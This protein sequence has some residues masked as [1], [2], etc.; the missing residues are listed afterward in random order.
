MTTRVVMIA[1]LH[2]GSTVGL[3]DATDPILPAGDLGAPVRKALYNQY[4]R[5][6]RGPWAK[7]D[8]LVVNGDCVEGQNRKQVGAGIW[9]TDILQQCS[10]A[11]GLIK[12]W[13]AK[14][15]YI[16]RGSPYHVQS[17]GIL[18]EEQIAR[19]IG[20][21][22]FPNQDH[23]SAAMRDHSG[24]H[25]YLT[26]EGV[27]FHISHKIGVSKLFHYMS[28]PTAREM[29]QAK[30]NDMLRYEVSKA[31]TRVIVR[32]HAHYY[33]SVGYSGSDGFVLPCW[34]G[35]DDFA[36]TQSPTLLSPDLGFLGFEVDGEHYRFEKNLFKIVDVQAV[37]HLVAGQSGKRK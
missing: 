23:V 27:T 33:N 15:V 12:M 6:T 8:V 19:K 3:A 9:S 28:T 14:T 32:A 18:A 22:E 37:P 11:E 10:M 25:L 29:L 4:C 1:D 34:K 36:L 17:G 2:V 35:L 24:W 26:V 20:A 7:P 30:L 21:E 5:A 31:K 13:K 16:V